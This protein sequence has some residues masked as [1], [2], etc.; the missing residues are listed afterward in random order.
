[1]ALMH[2]PAGGI[3]LVLAISIFLCSPSIEDINR[4]GAAPVSCFINICRWRQGF[5]NGVGNSVRLVSRGRYFS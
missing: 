4:N 5:D 3:A 1:M 2:A